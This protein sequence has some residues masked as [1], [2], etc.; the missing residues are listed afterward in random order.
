MV[1]SNVSHKNGLFFLVDRSIPFCRAFGVVLWEIATLATEPYPGLN[2]EDV[3]HFVVEESGHMNI[4]RGCP[5]FF[6]DLMLACW[7]YAANERPTF[8][9]L[10]GYLAPMAAES[11]PGF[12]RVTLHFAFFSNLQ[13]TRSVIFQLSLAL[14]L[15]HT[16]RKRIE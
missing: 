11:D 4:P 16:T 8:E 9:I 5:T 14:V 7:K 15:P 12:S 13:I 1:Y 2:Q 10:V 3:I 6:A